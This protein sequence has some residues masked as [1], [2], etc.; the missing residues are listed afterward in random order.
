[1]TILQPLPWAIPAPSP[2][3]GSVKEGETPGPP[4]FVPS[5]A[6]HTL[7]ASLLHFPFCSPPG[8]WALGKRPASGLTNSHPLDLL[9]LMMLQ[10][11]QMH[12][13]LLSG[14][15]AAVLNQV[16]P[17]P[18][19]QVR[20]LGIGDWRWRG[21][22][23]LPTCRARGGPASGVCPRLEKKDQATEE[24]EAKPIPL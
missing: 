23:G 7:W 22:P 8:G 15:V 2:Q 21:L 14:Q 6:R 24:P 17:W 16:P 20:G 9:E 1:M 13:L 10:N 19:P 12:Q 18:C 4:H 3:P 5:S 11:A